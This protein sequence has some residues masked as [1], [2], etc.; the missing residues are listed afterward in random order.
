MKNG[1]AVVSVGRGFCLLPK[2]FEKFEE[3]VLTAA[4]EKPNSAL[5][6]EVE[7]VTKAAQVMRVSLFPDNTA[8]YGIYSPNG[9]KA[10]HLERYAVIKGKLITISCCLE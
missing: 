1:Q 6:K 7:T 2:D 4:K 8:S 3:L 10:F 5:L 9:G